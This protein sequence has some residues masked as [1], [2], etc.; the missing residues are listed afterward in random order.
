MRVIA[1]F[2]FMTFLASCNSNS[3]SSNTEEP[4]R[5]DTMLVTKEPIDRPPVEKK[6]TIPYN[7]QVDTVINFSFAPDS[8]SLTARGSINKNYHPVTC[9]L[10]IETACRLI[11]TIIPDDNGLN[12]RFS[13]LIMPDKT[14]DG[15]FGRQLRYQLKQKGTYK[16]IISPNTMAEGKR[17]GNF[18]VQL[19]LK[20]I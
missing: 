16:L 9:Y 5:K 1:L 11:A 19:Q 4:M 6:D 15:P 14:S 3:H 10:P 2:S 13:H 20:P 7:V 8:S 18:Q 17:S 12:I